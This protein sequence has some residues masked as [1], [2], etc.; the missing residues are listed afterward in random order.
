MSLVS[1][2]IYRKLNNLFPD[3]QKIE[4]FT[5]VDFK[6]KGYPD[7][8]LIVLESTPEEINFILTRHENE[9]GQLIANPSIEIAINTK[10]KTANVI[11]YKDPYYFHTAVPE[12]D[13]IGT[14]ALCQAN[15]FLYDWL[16]DLGSW[17]RNL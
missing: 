5:K 4:P 7:I 12:P 10:E 14:I 16:K 13:E 15:R 2:Q 8:N 1:K 9:R 11:T 6:K 17:K 3:L